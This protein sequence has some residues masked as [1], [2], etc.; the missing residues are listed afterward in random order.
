[1]LELKYLFS[2]VLLM[3]GLLCSAQEEYVVPIDT[4]ALVS[5]VRKDCSRYVKVTTRKTKALTKRLKK[6]NDAYFGAFDRAQ[7]KL[8]NSLCSVNEQSAEYIRR[9]AQY[10]LNRFN[11]M[12]RREGDSPPNGRYAPIKGMQL[13]YQKVEHLTKDSITCRCDGKEE[14]KKAKEELN[15]ELKRSEILQNYFKERQQFL[16]KSLNNVPE[17]QSGLAGIQKMEYYFN[18]QVIESLKVFGLKGRWEGQFLSLVQQTYPM[19]PANNDLPNWPDIKLED[20]LAKAPEDSKKIIEELKKPLDDQKKKLAS[21]SKELSDVKS[22]LEDKKAI[23]LDSLK[24]NDTL[25]VKEVLNKP[26]WKPNPLKNKRFIDRLQFSTSLQ[27]DRKTLWFPASGV[28]LGALAFQLLPR[29]SIGIGGQW[30]LSIEK[31]MAY[32][33]DINV[34]KR[35]VSNGGAGIR[36]FADFR[37][38][39]PLFL[40]F[41]Y[42]LNHRS[43]GSEKVYPF[44]IGQRH[45]QPS[46]LAG[47]KLKY[48]GGKRHRP[49]LEIMYDLLSARTGQPAWVVRTG[50][51]F[52]PKNGLR[53]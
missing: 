34:R 36:A 3:L 38:T 37:I 6:A 32:Y 43:F 51:E 13:S 15:R 33:D 49:S 5:T 48:T 29:S 18:G 44:L 26:S 16:S 17:A 28:L 35:T 21:E 19:V 30:L 46:C 31:R 23:A 25:N 4:A 27:A 11:N 22:D 39:R 24:S 1:M 9:D 52:K 50:I 42:E 53:Q 8:L 7:E 41:S 45:W 12:V 20:L 2:G 47:L 14:L 40:Q 10:S